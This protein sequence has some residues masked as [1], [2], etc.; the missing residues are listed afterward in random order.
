MM[1]RRFKRKNFRQRFRRPKRRFTRRKNFRSKRLYIPAYT[2]KGYRNVTLVYKHVQELSWTWNLN[3]TATTA[4]PLFQNFTDPWLPAEGRQAEADATWQHY[5]R[6]KLQKFTWKLDN[7]RMWKTDYIKL[8]SSTSPSTPAV[9]L[10]S[11]TRINNWKLWYKR[12]H[13]RA[14]ETIPPAEEQ[15]TG[16]HIRGNRGKIWG[17]EHYRPGGQESLMESITNK[18]LHAHTFDTYLDKF[19]VQPKSE[20]G[21]VQATTVGVFLMPD[22]PLPDSSYAQFGRTCKLDIIA[23]LTTYTTF[24]CWDRAKEDA[25]VFCK[26]KKLVQNM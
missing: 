13:D 8:P 4:T 22:D 25:T 26:T 11:T 23:D 18:E 3:S 12:D 20:D 2:N 10:L 7:F 9:Q 16:T 19:V 24:S 14:A 21:T 1:G 15:M 17:T 5:K 6:H